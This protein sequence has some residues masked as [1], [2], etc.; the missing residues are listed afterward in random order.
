[1]F[2]ITT[3]TETAS[4]IEEISKDIQI[5]LKTTEIGFMNS[6]L[7]FLALTGVPVFAVSVDY[8]I[9]YVS[10]NISS[11]Q[12][13]LITKSVDGSCE[14]IKNILE[15]GVCKILTELPY[16]SAISYPV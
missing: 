14:V 10:E 4:F 9:A 13:V 8:G 16:L 15:Y 7:Y 5:V 6:N 3:N 12:T 1:M 2:F 11:E